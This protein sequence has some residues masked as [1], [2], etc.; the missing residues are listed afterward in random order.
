MG[1]GQ[2]MFGYKKVDERREYDISIF[3]NLTISIASKI[4]TRF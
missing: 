3:N 2:G 4:V 1:I